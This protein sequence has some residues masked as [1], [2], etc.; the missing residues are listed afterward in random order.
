M[1][2]Q[3]GTP[4]GNL[5]VAAGLGRLEEIDALAPGRRR[6]AGR[7][8]SGRGFYRPHSGFPA[9][10]PSDEPGEVLDEALAWATRSDRADAL[11]DLSETRKGK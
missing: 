11:R 5:R 4:P 8:G 2:H 9:W 3:H 10:R 1:H 7:A 6:V